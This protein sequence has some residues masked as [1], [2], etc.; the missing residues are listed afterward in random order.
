MM[1]TSRPA[2]GGHVVRT[3]SVA[4]VCVL[5][6]VT[7]GQERAGSTE[8]DKLKMSYLISKRKLGLMTDDAPSQLPL[9]HPFHA[10]FILC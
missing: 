10:L 7:G 9:L 6:T 4:G 3:P 5:N 1:V 2:F 8:A